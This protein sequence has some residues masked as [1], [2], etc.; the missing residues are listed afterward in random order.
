MLKNK[1]KITDVP[2]NWNREQGTEK[3][4]KNRG[5]NQ[6]PLPVPLAFTA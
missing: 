3:L 5:M 4:P 2:D 1:A 6:F